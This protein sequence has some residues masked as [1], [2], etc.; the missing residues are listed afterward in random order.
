MVNNANIKSVF[1][2]CS[3][4]TIYFKLFAFGSFLV[5]ISHPYPASFLFEYEQTMVILKATLKTVAVKK[6]PTI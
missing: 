3:R 6:K 2:I 4:F 5:S 1:V